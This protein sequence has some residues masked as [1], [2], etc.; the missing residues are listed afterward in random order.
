MRDLSSTLCWSG[1]NSPDYENFTDAFQTINSERTIFAIK[2]NAWAFRGATLSREMFV[3]A[4]AVWVGL[5]DPKS[6]SLFLTRQ[7]PFRRR[8]PRVAVA[9]DGL[10]H[11]LPLRFRSQGYKPPK[12]PSA[13]LQRHLPR[14]S[15]G[16]TGHSCATYNTYGCG[17]IFRLS[18]P[19]S[20]GGAW[21]QNVLLTLEIQNPTV[22]IQEDNDP[23]QRRLLRHNSLRGRH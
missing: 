14:A 19:S 23:S 13:G 1:G 9:A 11:G 8:V 20:P 18:P 2:S 12:N 15:P 22:P 21:K 6:L 10:G 17:T 3:R 5:Q 16:G 4:V 7:L